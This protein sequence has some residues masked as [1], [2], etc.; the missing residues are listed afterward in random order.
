[1]AKADVLADAVK[2]LFPANVRPFFGSVPD[3]TTLPWSFVLISIPGASER[4]LDGRISTRRCI[5]RV[6]IAGANDTAVRRV[7]D[8]LAPLVEGVRPVASGWKT[9][10]LA[11][12]GDEPQIFQDRDVKVNNQYPIV[13]AVDFEFMVTELPEEMP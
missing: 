10:P 4:R 1:M 12:L 5:V 3:G 11:Q 6:R 2:V 13:C 9:S 8:N 7:W